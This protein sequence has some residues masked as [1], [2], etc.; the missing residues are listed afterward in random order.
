MM[1]TTINTRDSHQDWCIAVQTDNGVHL[2]LYDT[3][4]EAV[5]AIS[6]HDEDCNRE[7]M[8]TAKALTQYP[9]AIM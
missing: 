6:D 9:D 1:K 7:V 8:R 5:A 4:R 3:R 2:D